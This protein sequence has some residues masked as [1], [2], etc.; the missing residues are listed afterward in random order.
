[1]FN[2]SYARGCTP[3]FPIT[4]SYN[5][6][7]GLPTRPLENGAQPPYH[8]S[9][10]ELSTRVWPP[11]YHPSQDPVNPQQLPMCETGMWPPIEE[12]V[13]TLIARQCSF[14]VL[15]GVDPAALQIVQNDPCLVRALTTRRRINLV[16]SPRIVEDIIASS[17]GSSWM[18]VNRP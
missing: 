4:S 7:C 14:K 15:L 2:S 16:S 6:H 12:M 10:P 9:P 3:S 18:I 8:L 11:R 17:T 13:I 1:M 5:S